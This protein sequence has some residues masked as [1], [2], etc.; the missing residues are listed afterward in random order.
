M[1]IVLNNKRIMTKLDLTKLIGILKT[2][3]V[4][5]VKV[6]DLDELMKS[7]FNDNL[8]K[9]YDPLNLYSKYVEQYGEN[10]QFESMVVYYFNEILKLGKVSFDYFGIGSAY[11][12][13]KINR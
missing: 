10:Y 1:N 13:I 9:N 11:I 12:E 3:G 7:Q 5:E 8:M 2:S 6:S 4:L